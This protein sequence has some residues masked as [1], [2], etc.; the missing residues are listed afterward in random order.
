MASQFERCDDP[1]F[2]RSLQ[3]SSTSRDS[4]SEGHASEGTTRQAQQDE[5]PLDNTAEEHG[6]AEDNAR[7]ESKDERKDSKDE[8]RDSKD[9]KKDKT[10]SLSRGQDTSELE[11]RDT[12][13]E[14][15]DGNVV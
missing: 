6:Q 12:V 14:N 13:K 4:V 7:K 15:P 2:F 3:K 10:D 5:G 11:S 1:P 9:D 8:K